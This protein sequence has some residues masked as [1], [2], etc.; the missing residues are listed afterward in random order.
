MN[1]L[2]NV[3]LQ[4]HIFW[5]GALRGK[6]SEDDDGAEEKELKIKWMTSMACVLLFL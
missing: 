4:T 6:R 2:F 3:N 5:T 1:G